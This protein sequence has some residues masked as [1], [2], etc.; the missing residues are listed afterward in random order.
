MLASSQFFVCL[1]VLFEGAPPLGSAPEA[2]TLRGKVVT[3]AAALE[4]RGLGLKADAEPIAKQVVLLAEDGSI[5]PLLSDEASRALFLDERLRNCRAEIQGR[6]FQGMPYLQVSTFKVERDGRLQAPES[7]CDVCA[8]SVHH[9]QSC[10]CCQGPR[11]L[12]MKPDRR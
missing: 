12:R 5:T 11:V 10:P 1:W 7:F 3:L 4:S 2:V 8:I 6:R 9:P